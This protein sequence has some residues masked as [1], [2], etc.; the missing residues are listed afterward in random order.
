MSAENKISTLVS[1]SLHSSCVRALDG[2]DDSTKPYVTQVETL[3]DE[4]RQCCEHVH[5]AREKANRNQAWTD[6]NKILMTANLADS[7]V[8]KLQPRL[9]SVY[10]NLEKAVAHIE[11]ELS[12]P[13]EQQAGAGTVNG[14]IRSHAKSLNREERTALI[15]GAIQSGDFK[16]AGAILGA[17]P[18]LS[19]LSNEEHV[20]YTRML[21]EKSNPDLTK[22]LSVLKGARD[23]LADRS[24]LILKELTK[25][26][27][28][29]P[30][31]VA[32]I[33]NGDVA[34]RDALTAKDF[35]PMA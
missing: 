6:G 12:A 24:K 1:P 7:Y 8:K 13:I 15:A 32:A 20:H 9:E 3:F 18:Y 5:A 19:G 4:V 35:S 2:Y 10:S 22:R 21:H 16:T 23:L 29:K 31:Q 28:A 33:R 30:E 26:V 25:A 17:P 14:E 27:G 34:A 11:K